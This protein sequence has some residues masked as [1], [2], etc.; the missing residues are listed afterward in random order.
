MEGLTKG[1]WRT[2][3]QIATNWAKR[4][5]GKRLQSETLEQVEALMV[6]HFDPAT[7]TKEGERPESPPP[8]PPSPSP[9]PP[10]VMTKQRKQIVTKHVIAAQIHTERENKE[11]KRRAETLN[12]PQG[13]PP[14]T[15]LTVPETQTHS[16][17]LV[18]APE[19]IRTPKLVT[20]A[21][22]TEETGGWTPPQEGNL[23]DIT[24]PVV[25]QAPPPHPTPTAFEDPLGLFPQLP[26]KP[27]R[28]HRFDVPVMEKTH[29]EKGAPIL[30]A[31]PVLTTVRM[32][33]LVVH[34]S[35]SITVISSEESPNPPH[36]SPGIIPPTQATPA[37]EHPR[38][39][40]CYGLDRPD[41]LEVW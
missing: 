29:N 7:E 11:L 14:P 16:P 17:R 26:P 15:P 23:I 4:N 33:P 37:R 25:S 32:N 39:G 2:P 10:P 12:E 41:S 8:P 21:T 30:T 34:T 31:G 3:F 9:P 20:M 1:D 22:M 28:T 18:P 24:E 13:S 5:L 6:V 40:S 36:L 35:D 19:N 38:E 27:Q